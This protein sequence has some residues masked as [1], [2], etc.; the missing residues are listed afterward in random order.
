MKLNN[1][2]KNVTCFVMLAH[3][4]TF[5]AHDVSHLAH[6]C[7]V[8][9]LPHVVW[10]AEVFDYLLG[11]HAITPCFL[12][13][14]TNTPN[15]CRELCYLERRDRAQSLNDLRKCGKDGVDILVCGL[16][17]GAYPQAPVRHRQRNPNRNKN[18]AWLQIRG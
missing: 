1:Y 2:K 12:Y 15:R 9:K 10:M 16:A 18:V 14:A 6:G 17:A 3:I 5:A 11:V 7:V 8:I 4:A 13:S